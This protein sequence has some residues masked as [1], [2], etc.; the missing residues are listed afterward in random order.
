[1]HLE[2]TT[3]LSISIRFESAKEMIQGPVNSIEH[4]G[5][6]ATVCYKR[7]ASML[8]ERDQPY[9]TQIKPYLLQ[10]RTG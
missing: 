9:S 8:A 2:L 7:L 6:A 1:M 4:M 3:I 10:C 5:P